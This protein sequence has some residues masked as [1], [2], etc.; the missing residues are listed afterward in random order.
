MSD[1]DWSRIPL[2]RDLPAA[3]I[4]KASAIFDMVELLAG[5]NLLEEGEEGDELYI[6]V[7]G[8]VRVIKAML[9]RGMNLPLLEA[10]NPHKVLATLD[11]AEYPVFGEVALLDHDIR[12]AT[13]TAVEDCRFLRT[14]R[15]RF[16]QLVEREP[17][18][19]STLLAILGKRLAETVRRSNTELIKLT[20]ALALALARSRS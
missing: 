3:G 19:G 16:F 5:Q 11:A 4:K 18:L 20:T 10:A 13:I 1:I 8:R 15:D 17:C 9:L 2:F 14:D 6:L 7:E 12:S